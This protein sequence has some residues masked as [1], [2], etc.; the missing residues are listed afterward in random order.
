MRQLSRGA[1]TGISLLLSDGVGHF[2]KDSSPG[3]VIT[4]TLNQ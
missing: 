4:L 2:A 1:T 3:S